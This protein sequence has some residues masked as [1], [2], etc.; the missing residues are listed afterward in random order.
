MFKNYILWVFIILISFVSSL[1]FGN[2][3]GP[4]SLAERDYI[5]Y[6]LKTYTKDGFSIVDTY[7]TKVPAHS[8]TDFMD[9]VDDITTESITSTI[10]TIVH[11]LCHGY[12]GEL[13]SIV[14]KSR[15]VSGSNYYVYINT[16]DSVLVK[17]TQT[18]PSK[19]MK[20]E[21][22]EDLRTYR[23]TYIDTT[24]RNLSTQAH[25]IYGLLDEYN[26]YLQGTRAGYDLYP[27]FMKDENTP[28]WGNYFTGINGTLY[29]I[30]EF[31]FF[32]LKYLLYAE[33]ES[34]NVY[35]DIINNR[36]FKKAF[37]KISTEA[38]NFIIEY[39]KKKKELFEII[40]KNNVTIYDSND[41]L[42]I[43]S[44]SLTTNGFSNF[45]NV[46]TTLAEEME[47][48]VYQSLMKT[49]GV[50]GKTLHVPEINASGTPDVSPD[51][52]IAMDE[53]SE[54]FCSRD[55][56]E[57]TEFDN[58][59]EV[60]GSAYPLHPV[61]PGKITRIND[62]KGPSSI[63]YADITSCSV[64]YTKKEI[65]LTMNLVELP[66]RLKVNHDG[67]NP[68]TMEYNW[69][70]KIDVDGDRNIELECS[71]SH[72]KEKGKKSSVQLTEDVMDSSIYLVKKNTLEYLD[73]PFTVSFAAKSIIFT[74]KRGSHPLI[75]AMNNGCFMSF[76]SY[77]YDGKN[78]EADTIN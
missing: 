3:P 15:G 51:E 50:T 78:Y 75:S 22:S 18:F 37:V 72:V 70:F 36:S 34:K 61:D 2:D 32:I 40:R 42:Y 12:T 20:N 4:D 48:P 13:G 8:R 59:D 25:G 69:S 66:K 26:A 16:Q 47:K 27:L 6:L 49:L 35:K 30:L 45:F 11:E 55:D 1:G 63:K 39:L 10:N 28:F 60:S 54:E 44:D 19:D 31:K 7:N 53:V 21:F 68:N 52:E 76:S 17:L 67:V 29:G 64:E 73:I 58:G 74:L 5:L 46:Y 77:Y 24:Q 14:A 23:F 38:H 56:M 57:E 62:K 41:F 33:K 71:V 9:Y 65:L 43:S